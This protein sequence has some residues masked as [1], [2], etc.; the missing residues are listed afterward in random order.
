MKLTNRVVAALTLDTSESERIIWDDDIPGLGLRMRAGGSRNWVFQYKVGAKHRRMTLGALSAVP[1]VEAR[2]LARDLYAKVR[3]GED[4]AAVKAVSKSRAAET[5]EPIARR[6]LA[7]KK[8]TASPDYYLD[9]ERDMM[10]NAK[11]L[12]GLSVAG[13]QRRDV[14]ELLSSLRDKHSDITADHVRASLSGFF[15]WA[16]NEGLVE[17]NPATGTNRTPAKPRDRVLSPA[18]LREIWAA[19]KNDTYGDLVRLLMLTAQ[20]RDEFG[21]VRWSEIDFNKSLIV[22]PPHAPRIGLSTSYRCPI[23]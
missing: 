14:A 13:I 1:L 21:D 15:T 9:M 3:L 20:R 11:P 4:P 16:M 19:L 12:H 7:H 6:F 23:R 17:A 22:F 8:K 10:I 18:E 2:E 5:F